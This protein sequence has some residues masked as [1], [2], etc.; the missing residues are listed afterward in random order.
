MASAMSRSRP[1]ASGLAAWLPLQPP[2]RAPTSRVETSSAGRRASLGF[3]ITL[4]LDHEL[5]PGR[6]GARAPPE[7]AFD[8]R[9][10]GE[11]RQREAEAVAG[12]AHLAGHPIGGAQ[13]AVLVVHDAHHLGT[14]FA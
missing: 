12:Q 2:A 14:L 9:R 8:Q 4:L 7:V 13:V 1:P 10:V 5:H 3:L 11:R 6:D